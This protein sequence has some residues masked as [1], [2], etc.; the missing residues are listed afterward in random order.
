[1]SDFACPEC[2]DKTYKVVYRIKLEEMWDH[3][4]LAY[5]HVLKKE[6]VFLFLCYTCG[7]TGDEVAKSWLENKRSSKN[8]SL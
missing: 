5:A 8:G 2:Q 3:G 6:D 1:M 7:H 4:L